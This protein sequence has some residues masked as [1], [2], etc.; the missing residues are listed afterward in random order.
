MSNFQA[1]K[2]S[3]VPK[4]NDVGIIARIAPQKTWRT[5]FA[6]TI[7]SGVD[8]TYFNLLKTGTGMTVAQNNGNLV[9]NNGTTINSE[10]VIRSVRAWEDS[11]ILKYQLITGTR[12]ANQNYFVEM[13]DVIG[14]GLACT[15]NSATSIT[16]PFLLTHL[17]RSMLVSQCM[18]V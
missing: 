1:P 8:S 17:Q 15:V 11:W 12:A 4:E 7:A 13:V 18:L 9:I 10:T 6:Q 14:D 2:T 5:T 3:A 16:V